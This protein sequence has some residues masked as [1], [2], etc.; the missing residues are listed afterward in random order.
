MN[1]YVDFPEYHLFAMSRVDEIPHC[2][3]EF[4]RMR[5]KWLRDDSFN[6]VIAVYAEKFRIRYYEKSQNGWVIEKALLG[7]DI[8]L[9]KRLKMQG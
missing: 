8:Q 5:L 1:F 4:D 3:L 2:K 6:V 7:E 9:T